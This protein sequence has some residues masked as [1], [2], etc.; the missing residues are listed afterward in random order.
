MNETAQFVRKD[1]M[2]DFFIYLADIIAAVLLLI[3]M[4]ENGALIILK[5]VLVISLFCQG[6]FSMV[7]KD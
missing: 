1:N 4:P 7:F 6:V 2:L 5:M 3:F